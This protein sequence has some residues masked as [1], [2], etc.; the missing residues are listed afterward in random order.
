VDRL[1]TSIDWGAFGGAVLAFTLEQERARREGRKVNYDRGTIET[2]SKNNLVLQKIAE[3]L[4]IQELKEVP[5]HERVWPSYQRGW[6]KAAGVE[7]SPAQDATLGEAARVFARSRV[8]EQ[9]TLR[10]S[11]RLEKLAWEADRGV[12]WDGEVQKLLSPD[13]IAQVANP[14][15]SDPF[16]GRQASRREFSLGRAEESAQS[17][18]DFWQSTLG[19]NE[20][21]RPI[22]ANAAT[23]YVQEVGRQVAGFRARYPET[24]PR[25]E[26]MRLRISLLRLQTK[27]ER[28]LAE[29]LGLSREQRE[30]VEEGSGTVVD[31]RWK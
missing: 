16:W 5:F 3:L 22:V 27:V 6:M 28:A 17:V 19:L 8:E 13:Q 18:G 31:W 21:L 30:G 20:S 29:R 24:A 1:V 10:D 2:L 25:D 26:E 7:L 9:R 15:G 23:D 14:A 11:N 12:R 4:G